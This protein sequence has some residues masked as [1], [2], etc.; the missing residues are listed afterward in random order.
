MEVRGHTAR[1][2]KPNFRVQSAPILV[3]LGSGRQF[4]FLARTRRNRPNLRTSEI[5]SWPVPEYELLNTF[6]HNYL[7]PSSPMAW[8]LINTWDAQLRNV[9]LY[10][11]G[12]SRL[13]LG[14]C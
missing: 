13:R 12:S 5:S 10:R 7:S 6:N 1:D 2:N 11:F 8:N 14:F 4:S 3:V 9:P